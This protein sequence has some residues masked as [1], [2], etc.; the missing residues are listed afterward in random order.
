MKNNLICFWSVFIKMSFYTFFKPSWIMEQDTYLQD[1]SQ[2][3]NEQQWQK[4]KNNTKKFLDEKFLVFLN[5]LRKVPKGVMCLEPH[6]PPGLKFCKSFSSPPLNFLCVQI[7]MW[8]AQTLTKML[9]ALQ[10]FFFFMCTN[11]S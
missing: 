4:K 7:K 9:W 1:F 11:M 5:H 6:V 3:T 10:I 8:E 2:K